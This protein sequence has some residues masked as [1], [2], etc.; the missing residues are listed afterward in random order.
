MGADRWSKFGA[1][2]EAALHINIG[3]PQGHMDMVM[4]QFRQCD[5]LDEQGLG[6]AEARVAMMV[7]ITQCQ[8]D[9]LARESVQA[10]KQDRNNVT[11]FAAKR[12]KVSGAQPSAIVGLVQQDELNMA[13]NEHGVWARDVF[14][15]G[16]SLPIT[17]GLG[18]AVGMCALS[19]LVF[20]AAQARL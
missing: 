14:R 2:D 1:P 6:V 16:T 18:V 20:V 9:C 7:S 8:T 17:F 19:G 15:Y 11:L 13:A 10:Q 4:G 12:R 5:A 3:S